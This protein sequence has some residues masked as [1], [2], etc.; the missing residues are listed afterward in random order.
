MSG[1]YIIPATG[2]SGM[3]RRNASTDKLYRLEYA[4][5][6]AFRPA[7]EEL[8]RVRGY[9]REEYWTRTLP[10]AIY[11]FLNSWDRKAVRAAITAWLEEH[12]E[13]R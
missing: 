10:E 8:A 2:R 11:S 6:E 1:T 3:I 12:A 7:V 5:H 4:T 9:P 13:G